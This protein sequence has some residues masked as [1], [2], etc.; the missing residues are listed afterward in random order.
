MSTLVLIRHAA[1]V[2][3]EAKIFTG[4]LD[5][6]ISEQGA[7]AAHTL[8]SQL[9]KSRFTGFV[10]S[11]M[12]RARQTMACLFPD[13]QVLI[14]DDLRE[15]SLGQWAGEPKCVIRSKQPEAFLHSGIMDPLFTPPGGESICELF[16]RTAR[17]IMQ[18]DAD[19]S[20][21]LL[22]V[23]HNGVIRALRGLLEARAI[24]DIFNE[25]EPC[26][27]PR[28]YQITNDVVDQV[29]IYFN[30]ISCKPISTK[31]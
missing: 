19:E 15:R 26:L 3:V 25:S 14:N 29:R 20:Q 4:Q 16:T 23:T 17:F 6:P 18:I 30:A 21:C 8:G 22:V 24:G 11:P 27:V 2:L 13:V 12:I 28:E 9:E 5:V 31:V 10:S 1:T 7:R